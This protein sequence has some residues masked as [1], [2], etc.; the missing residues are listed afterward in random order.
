MPDVFRLD[1]KVALVTGAA[2]GIGRAIADTLAAAGAQVMY[3]DLVPINDVPPSC[4][5]TRLDVTDEANWE[6]AIAATLTQF[7]GLDVL[8]NNAGILV[9][10]FFADMELATFEQVMRINVTGTFLGIKH[11]VRAMRPGGA[12]G[13]GGAIINMSSIAGMSGAPL[14]GAYG[15]SKGAVRKM[16]KDAAIEFATLGYGIRVNSVHPAVIATDMGEAVFANYV[17]LTGSADASR[18]LIDQATPLKRVG[19]P[20]EVANVVRFLASDASSYMTGAEVM[21]DGGMTAS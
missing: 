19:T 18:A 20:Q 15:T 17:P 14:F 8:V 1:G 11:A 9:S 13:N 21:V 2:R 3:S 12:A 4:A 7:H 6:A 5:S 10:G 16:T